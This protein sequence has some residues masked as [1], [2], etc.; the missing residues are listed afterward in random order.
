MRHGPA[1]RSPLVLPD[2]D[3]ALRIGKHINQLETMRAEGTYV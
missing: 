2:S 1:S 3:V